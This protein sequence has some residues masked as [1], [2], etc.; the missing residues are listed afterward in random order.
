[1]VNY[2]GRPEGYLMGPITLEPIKYN[3][4]SDNELILLT[5]PSQLSAELANMLIA[6]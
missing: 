4:Y 1:V 3:N 2:T 5:V 6:G